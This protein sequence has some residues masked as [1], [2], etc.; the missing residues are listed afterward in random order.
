VEMKCISSKAIVDN[1]ERLGNVI[2]FISTKK[3]LL[4]EAI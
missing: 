3:L 4:C 1:D 2:L